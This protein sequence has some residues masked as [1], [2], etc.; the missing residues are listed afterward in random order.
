MRNRYSNMK[1]NIYS[2][3]YGNRKFPDFLQLLTKYNINILVDI[4]SNPFSR[5]QPSYRKSILQSLVQGEGIKYVFMGNE[6]GGKPKAQIYYT[7]SGK[8]DLHLITSTKFYRNAISELI[9]LTHLNAG[10]CIMCSE[11]NPAQ[12]HRK[13]M[14]GETLYREG[15]IINHINGNGK[16]EKHCNDQLFPSL[17]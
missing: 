7:Q 13:T 5:Y 6:L 17:F 15:I 12:C 3:G 4:R 1:P 8:L 10:V 16:I 9:G 2:I 14:I 11:I